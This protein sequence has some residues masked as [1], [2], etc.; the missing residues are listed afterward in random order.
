MHTVPAGH[1]SPNVILQTVV[2]QREVGSEWNNEWSWGKK[3]EEKEMTLFF[4]PS[5]PPI[6]FLYTL[7]IHLTA[8]C[9]KPCEMCISL[10]AAVLYIYSSAHCLPRQG[11]K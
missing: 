7:I 5:L 2:V 9:H 3:E 4:F 1:R 10:Q 6:L 8:L 11:L